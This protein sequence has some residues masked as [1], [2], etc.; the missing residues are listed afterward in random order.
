MFKLNKREDNIKFLGIIIFEII[1]IDRIRLVLYFICF[2]MI[3]Y[4][5]N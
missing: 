4:G 3:K 5:I 2:K 1:Y